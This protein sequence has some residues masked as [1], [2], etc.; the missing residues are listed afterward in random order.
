V[1]AAAAEVAPA[2]AA[3]ATVA[4]AV[5]WGPPLPRTS[6][7]PPPRAAHGLPH[8][9][10]TP[11]PRDA[12][13]LLMPRVRVAQSADETSEHASET[14]EASY[15]RGTRRAESNPPEHMLL[16]LPVRRHDGSAMWTNA[17]GWAPRS[18]PQAPRP[19]PSIS[20]T[21]SQRQQRMGPRP[22]HDPSSSRRD[23]SRRPSTIP[24]LH[25]RRARHRTPFSSRPVC[26][27]PSPP[28]LSHRIPSQSSTSYS[29][30]PSPHPPTGKK[31]GALSPSQLGN[32][33]YQVADRARLGAKR[34]RGAVAD[35]SAA[36]D[37]M[38]ER[39]ICGRCSAHAP[40]FAPSV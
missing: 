1:A 33:T 30:L 31:L 35:A 2:A 19:S 38:W 4:A 13:W 23:P 34:M 6:A 32:K 22:R 3:A 26:S 28:L 10:L 25:V 16:R 17:V 14:S 27:L 12:A 7:L 11:L 9:C 40:V 24:L 36:G 15:R 37:R 8:C 18:R 20:P 5:A 21:R 29:H 39:R